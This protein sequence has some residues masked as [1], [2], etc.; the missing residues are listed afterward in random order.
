MRYVLGVDAGGTKTLCLLANE[1]GEVLGKG[2]AGPANPHTVGLT[3][4]RRALAA[5]MRRATSPRAV[6]CVDFAYLGVAGVDRA[7]ERKAVSGIVKALNIAKRFHVDNDAVIALAGGTVCRPGV[8]LISGTGSIAFGVNG[9]GCRARSGGWGPMLGDE[10]SGY[11]IGRNALKAVMKAH[12]GRGPGTS[13]TRRILKRLNLTTPEQLVGYV[14][15]TPMVVPKIAELALV[16]LEESKRGDR[17][18]QRIVSEAAGELV[19]AALS[20]IRKLRMKRGEVEVVLCGG[21]FEYHDVLE[22][23]VKAN[24]RRALPNAVL[25]RPKFDP[26]VGAVLLGLKSL[27]VKLDRGLLER[28]QESLSVVE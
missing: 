18:S 17:V 15:A 7:Y 12:D 28:L 6:G 25:V 19:E 8:A 5:S 21:T 16:V 10:G 20:V 3:G 4:T 13:L 27:R 14:Y 26:A 9:E 23:L 24:L 2:V 1:H 11:D 22:S